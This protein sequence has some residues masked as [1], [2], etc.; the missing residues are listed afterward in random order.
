MFSSED[1]ALFIGSHYTQL[2]PNA[3]SMHAL[4]LHTSTKIIIRI[5]S[6]IFAQL[7]RLRL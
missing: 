5:R 7:E 2:E 3:Y 6:V 4:T 1:G